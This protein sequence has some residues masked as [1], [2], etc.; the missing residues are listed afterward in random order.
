LNK[1]KKEKEMKKL[2]LAML[3]A[4][5]LIFP[6]MLFA[7]GSSSTVTEGWVDG[8]EGG[9]Y[10]IRWT[11][12]GDDTNGT[13]PSVTSSGPLNGY[14]IKAVTDPGSPVP[15]TDYDIALADDDQADVMGGAMV[16]LSGTLSAVHMP[17]IGTD[18]YQP[19]YISSALTM[20]LTGNS[21]VDAQGEVVVYI[22]KVGRKY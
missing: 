2:F 3:L 21:N 19:V 10:W 7:A 22:Q 9:V 13:V 16:D 8:V 15:S 12:V 5:A 18:A 20:V 14:V 17:L 6:Q 4:A 1:T 11:W